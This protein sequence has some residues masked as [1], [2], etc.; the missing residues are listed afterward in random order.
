MNYK[1]LKKHLL[2]K[3]KKDLFETYGFKTPSNWLFYT[4]GEDRVWLL[5]KELVDFNTKNLNVEVMGLYF[6]FFDGERLRLSPEAAQ[7]IGKKAFKNVV[8]ISDKQ[9]EDLIRGFNIE[10]NTDSSAEYVIVKSSKGVLGVGKNHG[11]KILCQFRK[12][13][14]IRKL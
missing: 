4:L 8:M 14:R 12:N 11:D 9:A 5:S 2:K 6:S 7:L 13:R 10:K 1:P 3:F